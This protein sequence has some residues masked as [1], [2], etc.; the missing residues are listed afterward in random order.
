MRIESAKNIHKLGE[1]MWYLIKQALIPIAYLFIS[2]IIATGVFSIENCDP[3]IIVLLLSLNLIIYLFVVITLYSKEGA[4]AYAVRLSN[5]VT[6]KRIIE[7]GADLP[8]N[9]SK[10]YAPWKGFAFGGVISAT[11]DPK[12]QIVLDLIDDVPT[13]GLFPVGRLDKDSEGLLLIS[14]DGKLAHNLLSPKKHVDKVY[15]IQY[16][17]EL[18]KDVKKRFLEGIVLEDGYKCLSASIELI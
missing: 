6:R 17:N 15:Y 18:D 13:R 4:D 12:E 3:F 14:N 7:T 8:L 5:D 16:Q 2:S 9:T 1:T 11:Y 10:E